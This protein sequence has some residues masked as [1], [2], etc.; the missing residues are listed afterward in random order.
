MTHTSLS[1]SNAARTRVCCRRSK[2]GTCARACDVSGKTRGEAVSAMGRVAPGQEWVGHVTDFFF[3]LLDIILHLAL[4]P[5]LAWRQP[6]VGGPASSKKIDRTSHAR[7]P[8]WCMPS[9]SWS[10]R[11]PSQRQLAG[12]A[13]LQ[14]RR[15]RRRRRSRS[16]P[17][18]GC[19]TAARSRRPWPG[20]RWRRSTT[21]SSAASTRSSS[22]ARQV[23]APP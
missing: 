18:T 7:P 16:M 22:G 2:T 21:S 14:T 12:E 6:A 1:P 13:A 17:S 8:R 20:A 23:P 9:C 3:I 5:T 11:A 15:R 19:S 10:W 4:R